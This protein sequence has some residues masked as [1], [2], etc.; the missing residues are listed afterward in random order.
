[1]NRER[2]DELRR[3]RWKQQQGRCYI[4]QGSMMHWDDLRNDPGKAEKYGV[5]VI[6]GTIRIKRTPPDMATMFHLRDRYDPT[7]QDVNNER[8]VVLACAACAQKTSDE[9]TRSR[10]IE[11]L[12][13]RAQRHP[14]D[15][16]WSLPERMYQ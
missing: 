14:S 10:P 4:C 9:R 15:D 7:R 12:H 3:K 6:R 5:T 16:E 1:M 11:E 2:K 8:R 13:A